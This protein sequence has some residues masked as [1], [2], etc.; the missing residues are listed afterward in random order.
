MFYDAVANMSWSYARSIQGAGRAA[1]D[2]LDLDAR[3]ERRRQSRPL[4]LLQR[5]LRRPAFRDVC[6]R[7]P[8]GQ[9]AQ[10][11]GDRRVR[12]L[13]RHLRSA[14]SDEPDLGGGRPGGRRDAAGGAY[15]RA[16]AIG[17][18]AAREGIAGRVR[19][20]LLADHRSAGAGWLTERT[21]HRARPGRG[22]AHRRRGDHRRQ[23][24]CHQA[25]ADRPAGLRRL[26]GDRR[27]V[28][29]AAAGRAAAQLNSRTAPPGC[30]RRACGRDRTS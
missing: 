7:W 4:Q 12:L 19:M 8:Q 23:G 3:P 30:A 10:R 22:R 6:L 28:H 1:T 17:G 27:S 24:R 20:P 29:A 15:T 5:R 21:C 2:R 9:P 11:R 18:A 26:C 14:R 16:L 25:Q 13:A